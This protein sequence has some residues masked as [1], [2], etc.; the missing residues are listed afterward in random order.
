MAPITATCARFDAM[1]GLGRPDGLRPATPRR[2]SG[3][4]RPALRDVD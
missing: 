2:L 1:N 4:R 3:P